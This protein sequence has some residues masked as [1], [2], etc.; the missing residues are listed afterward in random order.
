MDTIFGKY[1]NKYTLHL[2]PVLCG[3]AKK[4]RKKTFKKKKRKRIYEN[5]SYRRVQLA[6]L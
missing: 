3:G 6:R 2:N 5:R 1:F 4:K